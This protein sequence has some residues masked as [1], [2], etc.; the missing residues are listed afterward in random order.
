[1]MEMRPPRKRRLSEYPVSDSIKKNI[2]D[3]EAHKVEILKAID[4]KI[5]TISSKMD[6]FVDM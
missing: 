2:L 3:N 6:R 5:E 4:S 1:M